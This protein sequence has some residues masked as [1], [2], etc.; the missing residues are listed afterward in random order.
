MISNPVTHVSSPVNGTSV[1]IDAAAAAPDTVPAADTEAA[2][3]K[4]E[5]FYH[6]GTYWAVHK[7]EKTGTTVCGVRG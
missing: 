4:Y 1:D 2:D 3:E 7:D 6:E 5:Q